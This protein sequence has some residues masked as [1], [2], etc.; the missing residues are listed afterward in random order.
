MPDITIS[1]Q[2]LHDG[3]ELRQAT[4]QKIYPAK[5]PGTIHT[6]LIRN[7]IIDDPFSRDNEN[8]LQWIGEKDWIYSTRFQVEAGLFQKQN[9]ELVFEGLDTYADVYL[10]DTFLLSANNM[11][12]TWRAEVK[13]K[14]RDGEN[15]LRVYFHNVFKVNRP[16][17][18]QAPVRLQAVD[19]NDQADVKLSVYSRKAG[20]HYGWDWGPR[21]ITY[22]IWRPVYLLGW[23]KVKLDSVFYHQ[24]NISSQ[25]ADITANFKISSNTTKGVD[26]IIRNEDKELA[27]TSLQLKEGTNT[28]D[29]SFRINRPN[30]WW[31]NGLGEP[32]RYTFTAEITDS[33]GVLVRKVDQIGLRKIRLVQ[34]KDVHGTSFYFELNEI[35]VFIKGASYIPQDNF[36][37]RIT[38][39]RY[40]YLISSAADTEMNMLRVWG[41]GIYENDEFYELCDRYGI[42]VWQDMMFACGMYPSD[43]QFLNNVVHEIRDNIRRLRNHACIVLWCGNNENEMIWHLHWKGLYPPEQQKRYEADMHHLF[44][45]VIQEEI[46]RYDGT[47]DYVPTSP[48]VGFDERPLEDGNVHYWDVWHGKAPFESYRNYIGRF[49][50][51]YGFQSF[52]EPESVKRFTVEADRHIQSEVLEAHQRCRAD[53]RR[54]KQYANRL[55]HH[56]MERYFQVP[57]NFESW[58][59][60]SQLVQ[61]KGVGTAIESHRR[62]KKS[63]FCMGT[64]YWQLNDCWPAI[65]WSSV[66]Y[67][68]RWKALHYHLRWLYADVLITGEFKGDSLEL[69]IISDKQEPFPGA[70]LEII[71]KTFEGTPITRRSIPIELPADTVK[72]A[73]KISLNEL[74]H[75]HAKEQIYIRATLK[76]GKQTLATRFLFPVDEKDMQLPGPGLS[77][78]VENDGRDIRICLKAEKFAKNLFLSLTDTEGRFSD[79][80]FDMEAG[81][82]K[83]IKLSADCTVE[84]VGEKIEVRS[85]HCR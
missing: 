81:E 40:E 59:Y 9:I 2:Y 74:K 26:L 56:Y 67:Y 47:R 77:F 53:E 34:N 21:L 31:C 30:L 72:T 16:E 50:T 63:R 14:L 6:D 23:D 41:G 82:E 38:E 35:P 27:K 66:D 39:D 54:D 45:E 58:L 64:I 28:Y 48:L 32:Y 79:N 80:Y 1:Q 43:N 51:E 29:L 13:G 33:D 20:F 49:M 12:R 25:S 65:S 78:N 15:T 42:M 60:V 62:Q 8:H 84:K 22:G 55:I 37:N 52:P 4:W 3:W 75:H 70:E 83:T 7:Q 68:G 44:S 76:Y 61:A 85:L 57:E 36:Q 73:G 19:N 71:T 69:F 11:F 18:E 46:H 17:W 24:L 10:N 5:I